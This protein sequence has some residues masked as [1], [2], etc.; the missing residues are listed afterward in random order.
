MFGSQI[1]YLATPEARGSLFN[2]DKL[3]LVDF[4]TQNDPVKRLRVRY[5]LAAI[6]LA[7]LP[8]YLTGYIAAQ[9]RLNQTPTPTP[10]ATATVTPTSTYTSTASLTLT[11]TASPTA[12]FTQT[13][14]PTLTPSRTATLTLSPLPTSTPP[15]PT[16]TP[17]PTETLSETP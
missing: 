8:C 7:T 17:V 15:P 3:G 16:D 9:W 5:V 1:A 12:T 11:I 10:S 2:D 13:L 4:F 6:I 14:I